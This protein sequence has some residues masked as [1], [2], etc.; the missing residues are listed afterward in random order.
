MNKSAPGGYNFMLTGATPT[1]KYLF[2]LSF[3]V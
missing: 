2:L 3:Q 1:F